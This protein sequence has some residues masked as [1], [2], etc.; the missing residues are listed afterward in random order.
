LVVFI[1]GAIATVAFSRPAAAQATAKP[2]SGYNQQERE[3]VEVVKGWI[4]AWRTHDIPKLMSYMDDKLVY[5]EWYDVPIVPL[6]GPPP[7][8]GGTPARGN[9]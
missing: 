7:T 3:A 8:P 5:R 1:L 2:P 6:P 9:Q 4:N